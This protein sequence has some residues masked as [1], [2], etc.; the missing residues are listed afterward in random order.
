MYPGHGEP[1]IAVD[2]TK[3][4]QRSPERFALWCGILNFC[5]IRILVSLGPH[6]PDARLSHAGVA[7]AVAG[8][9]A[10]VGMHEPPPQETFTD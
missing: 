1:L 4:R 5:T 7:E 3:P 8:F 9:V 6:L 10:D 2:R